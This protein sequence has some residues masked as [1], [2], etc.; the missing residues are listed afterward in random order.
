MLALP[1]ENVASLDNA[2]QLICLKPEQFKVLLRLL[3]VY[4]DG[5]QW[6]V[7][8][9][10]AACANGTSNCSSALCRSD[11]W[12]LL[13]SRI[14]SAGLFSDI[15]TSLGNL[16]YS[17]R[18]NSNPARA[19]GGTASSSS[20][21]LRV[22]GEAT[23]AICLQTMTAWLDYEIPAETKHAYTDRDPLR[24]RDV[25]HLILTEIITIPGVG[26]FSD[27]ATIREQ[28]CRSDFRLLTALV[29]AIQVKIMFE[30]YLVFATVIT[31]YFGIR[32]LHGLRTH[33]CLSLA[34]ASA[35]RSSNMERRS[36][37]YLIC[38]S[39]WL[40]IFPCRMLLTPGGSCWRL[41]RIRSAGLRLTEFI[42]IALSRPSWL[43]Y[44]RKH[45]YSG[46][47]LTSWS[48]PSLFIVVQSRIW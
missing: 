15:R 3:A 35:G 12:Q 44:H 43:R 13:L 30:R 2:P 47:S 14:I 41:S 1:I 21:L 10:Q 25:I 32:F 16:L 42:I 38:G 37:L 45:P 31:T 28:L 27:C 5:R 26:I 40:R 39:S 20:T 24:A 46:I 29:R 17:L 48:I 23:V 18:A 22:F 6:G 4:A 34:P 7:L 11:Q 8:E 9:H 19:A 33:G 36:S